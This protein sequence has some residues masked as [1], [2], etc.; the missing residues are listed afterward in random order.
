MAL[1]LRQQLKPAFAIIGRPNV[2]KSTLFNRITRTRDALVADVPGVTR[3]VKLGVG[4]VGRAAYL[5]VDTGGITEDGELAAAVTRQA[6][7]ALDEC[8][9][10]VFVVD[11]REGLT[12]TDE[13]LARQL[14]RSG[15]PIFLAVNKAESMNPDLLRGEYS[16]LGL[17]E[18]FPIS[19][20]HGVGVEDLV[21]T[22]TAGWPR[23]ADLER[24]EEAGGIRVAIV[25][26]PNVGKS[27]LVN[28]MLGEERMITADLPGT[29]HDS[30]AVPLER[31]GRRY[32]LIDTAGIRRRSRVTDVVEKFSAVK[33]LQAIDLAQ[34]VVVVLD[35]RESLAEQDLTVLGGVLEVGRS[36]VVAVNKWDGMSSE[37]REEMKRQLDRRIEFVDFAETR[38]ISALHGTGVGELF[39]AIDD[40]HRSAYIEVQTS[41]LTELLYRALEAHNPPLVNGRRI[42][43]RYAHM[44]GKNPPTIIIHGNQT[45]HVP[46][47]YRRYLASFYRKALRLIGTPVKIEFKQGENPF[48]G[49]KNPLTKRQIK[50]RQRLRAHIRKNA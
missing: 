4:R 5:V 2:G 20:A 10:G 41:D 29:T 7:H 14:R 34:V 12:A 18:A 6:L 42:K 49:R 26:R 47:S 40:A 43:L 24:E 36:L 32:T 21:A 16:G 9:A 35:A 31:H 3:D 48:H 11:A 37:A 27:T 45:E 28:R 25:G 44:G 23:L 39:G 50:K 22:V 8:A 33:T 30:V 1:E 13:E 19:A 46:D 38:Y 15:K 17:G